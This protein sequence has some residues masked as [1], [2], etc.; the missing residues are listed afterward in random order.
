[1]AKSKY[2]CY[3][4]KKR[5]KKSVKNNIKSKKHVV[6]DVATKSV[7]TAAQFYLKTTKSVGP[8]YFS[9]NEPDTT[10]LQC[11]HCPYRFRFKNSEGVVL[12]ADLI[13]YNIVDAHVNKH[14]VDYH[15]VV[16]TGSTIAVDMP[17]IVETPTPKRKINIIP[18]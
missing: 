2:P 15:S 5:R 8:H 12:C 9:V 16:Y 11:N 18:N 10:W 7:Q 6:V 13:N 14:I 3:C 4:D 17:A 1:M